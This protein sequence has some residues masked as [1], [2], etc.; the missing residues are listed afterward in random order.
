MQVPLS[1]R[2]FPYEDTRTWIALRDALRELDRKDAVHLCSSETLVLS[3]LCAALD[4]AGVF[5]L[6]ESPRTS[7]GR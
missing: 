2:P 1:R 5:S 7:V 4:R 6:G 3:V